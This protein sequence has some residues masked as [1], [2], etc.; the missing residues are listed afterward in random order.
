MYPAKTAEPIEMPFGTLIPVGPRN[1]VLDGNPALLPGM[2]ILGMTSR[3]AGFAAEQRSDWP[4]ND[5]VGCHVKFSPR[6][7]YA[8]YDAACLQITFGNPFNII[9]ATILS[10]YI[11]TLICVYL[12]AEN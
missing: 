9:I 12:Y 1:H 2:D 10:Q 3:L 7:K 8:P 4:A 5:A 6:K 11:F